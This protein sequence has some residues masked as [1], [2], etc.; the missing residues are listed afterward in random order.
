MLAMHQTLS[1]SEQKTV[2]LIPWGL[3]SSFGGKTANTNHNKSKCRSI[4]GQMV[5]S[6]MEK[7]QERKKMGSDRCR[8]SHR[9]SD[10]VLGH[11]GRNGVTCKGSEGEI[12]RHK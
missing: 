5:I 9:E 6:L 11:K 12:I 8:G 3:Q 1:I 4:L 7:S 2:S 10:V